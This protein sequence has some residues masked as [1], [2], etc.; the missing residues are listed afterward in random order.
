MDNKMYC[1]NCKGHNV[2][3]YQTD[4]ILGLNYYKCIDCRYI[5]REQLNA[6]P[7]IP[8]KSK[9][10]EK[11]KLW[12]KVQDIKKNRIKYPK[13]NK[14]KTN[15]V[16]DALLDLFERGGRKFSKRKKRRIDNERTKRNRNSR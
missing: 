16:V 1:P 3:M 5:W 10:P 6:L 13:W 9:E 8:D 12:R 4:L 14:I 15:D 2:N 11:E 7:L